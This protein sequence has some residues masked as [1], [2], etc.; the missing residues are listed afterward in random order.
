M[1]KTS[2]FS[3]FYALSVDDRAARV[4]EFAGL[5]PA[6]QAGL[7]EC[8]DL[9]SADQ[10]IE[11]VV[12]RFTLPLGVA[13]NFVVNG[14]EVLVPMAIEEPSVVAAC[15]YAARLARAAGGFQAEA[16]PPVMIGQ[17]QLLEV[18]DLDA[19]EQALRAAEPELLSA[20]NAL[21]PTIVRLGGG[22]TAI[23]VRRLPKTPVGPM[24]VVHLLLNTCDAMGA[25]AINTT[26]EALAPSIEALTGGRVNLRIL[27]NLADRRRARAAAIWPRAALATESF[28]GDAVVQGIFEAW[29]FAAADPYRA[30]THNKGILNGIDALAVATGNDWRGIEAGA[31]AY[32]ARDGRYT[33]LTTFSRTAE[34]DLHGSIELPLAVGIVGGTTRAHP[35]AQIALKILG[36][37]AATELAEIMAAVGLAQNFAAL[38]ALATEGIQ[39]GHMALHARQIALAAGASGEEVERV[40]RRLVAEGQVRLERARELLQ[41]PGTI[42][43]NL[44]SGES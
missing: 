23:D 3:G 19:A 37:S 21:H 5:T 40:A 26:C 17:I 44:S 8:L 36:I 15:S 34:G 20:A 13:V 22:A 35:T 10:L 29:A 12:G 27:S 41:P 24:L 42:S 2:A 28:S 16:D 4:A 11:N 25:N 43:Q 32:A 1:I 30:A 38:R 14:R 6:E 18:P 9:E 31:H 33:A 7:R 39:H